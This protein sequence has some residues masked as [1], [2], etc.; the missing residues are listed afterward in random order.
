MKPIVELHHVDVTFPS[1]SNRKVTILHDINLSISRGEI[2]TVIGESGCGKSTLG[3]VVL[4]ILKPSKGAVFFNSEYI[5]HPDFRW[6]P[7]LRQ[8]VQVIHQDP[9]SSLNPVR[10]I[11]QTLSTP[12]RFHYTLTSEDELRANVRQ[13]LED[14]GLSP[15]EFFIDKYPFQLSGGQKQRVSIART[16][17]M[18]PELIVADE[19]VS[20]VDASSKLNIL[21]IMKKMNDQHGIS[22]VYITHDL[23]TAK[24]FAPGGVMLVM[25]LGK[26]VERGVV[27]DCIDQPSHP[28]LQ[29]LL[30]ALIFSVRDKRSLPLKS[31]D[32]PSL[33]APPPGCVFHPRCPYSTDICS[34]TEPVLEPHTTG[35]D[36]LVA[37]H[38][39]ERIPKWKNPGRM[40]AENGSS[41]SIAGTEG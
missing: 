1:E 17:T 37:C 9:F 7:G 31:I 33:S 40:A 32:L 39:K 10:T 41:P 35:K 18:K 11:Y 21:T 23:A 2:I 20:G 29:A 22:F 12:F 4:G 25:Y 24:Y 30:S 8:L 26:I 5:W 14:V 34:R 13:L 6:T 36:H 15:P 28:Y 19:P 16:M 38:N 27:E 3:K